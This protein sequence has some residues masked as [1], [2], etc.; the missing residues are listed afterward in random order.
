MTSTPTGGRIDLEIDFPAS[1]AGAHY[2]VLM[3]A[4]GNGP[5]FDKIWIPLTVDSLLTETWNNHYPIPQY[6]NLQGYLDLD[7]DAQ[8]WLATGPISPSLIG[9][10][11]WLAAIAFEAHLIPK[12]SSIDIPVSITL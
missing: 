3:S 4:T 8:A 12:Y 9:Q 10:T 2:K 1:S 7:G 11:H 5:T 6:S